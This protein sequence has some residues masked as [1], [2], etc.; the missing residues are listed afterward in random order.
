MIL[1]AQ[2]E[3]GGVFEAATKR[4]LVDQMAKHY[5][6]NNCEAGQIKAIFVVRKDD[7]TN[8][9]CQ[10]VI[11][12]V[13]ELVEEAVQYYRTAMFEQMQEQ[14]QLRSDYWAGVL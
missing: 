1:V 9:A 13:Q 10:N 7:K 14:D 11:S 4:K 5:A 2:M 12:R 8:E 3:S 6:E